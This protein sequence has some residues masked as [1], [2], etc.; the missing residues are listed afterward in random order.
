M[1]ITT[2]FV[3][4]GDSLANKKNTELFTLIDD[5]HE[6]FVQIE[7]NAVGRTKTGNRPTGRL[8]HIESHARN[9]EQIAVKIQ[10]QVQEMRRM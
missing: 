6:N 2:H 3:K 10:Q 7:H 4:E 9:I 5:L 1:H 8:N